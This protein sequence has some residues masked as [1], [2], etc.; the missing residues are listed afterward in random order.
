ML[1]REMAERAGLVTADMVEL[2]AERAELALDTVELELEGGS[3]FT[4]S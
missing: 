4:K 1:L 2:G 3:I